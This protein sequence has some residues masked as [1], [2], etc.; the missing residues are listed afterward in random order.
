MTHLICYRM[1]WRETEKSVGESEIG[2]EK[3]IVGIAD[4]QDP[5]VG[6]VNDAEVVEG[7]DQGPE[8]DIEVLDLT[9]DQGREKGGEGHDLIQERKGNNISS[10]RCWILVSIV[11]PCFTC[12]FVTYLKS[13]I[14]AE[15]LNFISFRR[16]SRSR[17]SREREYTNGSSKSK[18]DRSESPT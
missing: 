10:L 6:L 8:T 14:S 18:N 5:E 15:I 4:V 11:G 17:G 2:I 1:I 7:I 9:E 12:N 16:R 3:G 13:Y